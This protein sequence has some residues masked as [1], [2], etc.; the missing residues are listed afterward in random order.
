MCSKR[1]LSRLSVVS[2]DSF[3][4]IVR[5][6]RR[7]SVGLVIH[8]EQWDSIYH[9]KDITTVSFV[10][11]FFR[12]FVRSFLGLLACLLV[13]LLV[14]VCVFPP[15]FLVCFSLVR[16]L[17]CLQTWF[18]WMILCQRLYLPVKPDT[19]PKKKTRTL[20][21]AQHPVANPICRNNNFVINVLFSSPSTGN[22]NAIQTNV[23]YCY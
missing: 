14:C 15:L 5:M 18:W 8:A 13:Y 17:W 1:V 9:T 20:K 4:V 12:S 16:T 22:D 19:I 23:H 2:T 7:L 3:V 21:V 11:S 10:R 6:L